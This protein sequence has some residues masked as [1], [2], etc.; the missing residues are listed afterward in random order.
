[1]VYAH[2][3]VNVLRVW[4]LDV[5]ASMDASPKPDCTDEHATPRSCT[6]SGWLDK[7]PKPTRKK[8][9]FEWNLAWRVTC[10]QCYV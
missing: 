9:A 7:C 2:H 5:S 8:E 3:A 10:R 6:E 1:M 4:N